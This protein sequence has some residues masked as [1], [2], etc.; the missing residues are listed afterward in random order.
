MTRRLALR[1]E[2]LTELTSFELSAVAGAAVPTTNCIGSLPSTN[3]IGP[4]PTLDSC[5]T[6]VW[7]TLDR[8]V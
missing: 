3:C 2:T 8:C 5:F 4:I 7:P 1:R 6:G